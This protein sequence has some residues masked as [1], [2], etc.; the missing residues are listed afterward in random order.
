[1]CVCIS[2]IVTDKQIEKP[3]EQGCNSLR[4]LEDELGVSSQCGYCACEAASYLQKP[5]EKQLDNMA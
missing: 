2:N 5:P 4:K 1:M 3:V